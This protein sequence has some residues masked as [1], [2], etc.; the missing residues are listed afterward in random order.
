[1]RQK[2]SNRRIRDNATR[3]SLPKDAKEETATPIQP[4]KGS[5]L[6]IEEKKRLEWKQQIRISEQHIQEKHEQEINSKARDSLQT[7]Q[8]KEKDHQ[9]LR[10]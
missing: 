2:T 3:P 8:T 1:M 5:R 9:Q 7:D 6:Q 10:H 4:Q